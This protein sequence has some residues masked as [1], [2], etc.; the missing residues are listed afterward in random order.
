MK[1]HYVFVATKYVPTLQVY[2]TEVHEI[3][4]VVKRLVDELELKS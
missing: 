3:T 1:V 2:S 4:F